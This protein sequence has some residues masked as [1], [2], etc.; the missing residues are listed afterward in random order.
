MLLLYMQNSIS[1]LIGSGFS[2]PAGVP[3][4]SKINKKLLDLKV[5]SFSID[6]AGNAYFYE[7]FPNSDAAYLKKTERSFFIAL[8]QEFKS[9]LPSG[10]EFDYEEFYDF[11]IK[12]QEQYRKN[13]TNR[14]I[15]NFKASHSNVSDSHIAYSITVLDL[16][17]FAV[18][19]L[20]QLIEFMLDIDNFDLRSY[21]K[22]TYILKQLSNKYILNI[23]SL[24]HDMLFEKLVSDGLE[25]FF[26][27][28]FTEYGSPF[29][30]ELRN[31]F[32]G[33]KFRL[34]YF[35]HE[36]NQKINLLKLH[37]SLDDYKFSYQGSNVQ[38]IVKR[39]K[40][41]STVDFYKE[42]KNSNNTFEYLQ[43][44]IE[45][46][47]FFLSGVESKIDYYD[48]E[49][50]NKHLFIQFK[51]NLQAAKVLIVIGYGFRDKKINEFIVNYYKRNKN[52]VM[53]IIDPFLN[54][55][56]L[57]EDGKDLIIKKGIQDI[58]EKDFSEILGEDIK[59]F[60]Y[61]GQDYLDYLIDEEK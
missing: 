22:F 51:Y 9:E 30:G 19:T 39:I 14:F 5:D 48:Y 47:S 45:Y 41:M 31:Y 57:F 43:C 3:G 25:R 44:W 2:I 59:T 8:I 49:F 37:G 58:T 40:N 36:Y 17:A 55:P 46:H 32:P 6:P 60:G 56:P 50:Y 35:N 7:S 4:V 16:Y 13:Q 1:F 28:G 20:N 53:V 24:N 34:R 18:R 54:L 10:Q 15:E 21:L 23:H 29:Y 52:G 11:L 12:S 27:D 42:I 38:D 26:S 61:L 33:L